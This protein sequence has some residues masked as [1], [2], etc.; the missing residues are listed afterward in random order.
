MTAISMNMGCFGSLGII[1]VLISP[2]QVLLAVLPGLIVAMLAAIA[3]LFRPRT[4]WN[5]LKLMWRLKIPLVIAAAV[6]V[7]MVWIVKTIWPAGR[8]AAASSEIAGRDWPMFR[9]GPGRCGAVGESDAPS[10]AAVK[11]I[12]KEGNIGFFCSPAVVGNRIYVTSADKDVFADA[13]AI[14]CLDANNR[15]V[16]WKTVPDGYLATFS[17]PVVSGDYVVC[18]EGLHKTQAARII[19]LRRTTG[20][21]VWMFR[22]NHHVECTPAVSEGRVY[23]GAGDD[24][25]YCLALEGGGNGQ[26]KVL[27]HLPSKDYPDAETSLVACG[28]KVYVGLGNKGQAICAIDGKT[29]KELGRIP[30]PYTVFSPPAVVGGKLY[31]GMGTGDFIFTAEE[32]HLP[33]AGEVWCVDLAG[34]KVDWKFKVSQ[35]VLGAI[36]ASPEGYELYFGSRDGNLYCIGTDGKQRWKWNAFSQILTSPAVTKNCVY[37]VT[38]SGALHAI[39]RGDGQPAWEQSLGS[40]GTFASSPSVS[41]SDVYV[42]T[43]FDGLFCLSQSA[44]KLTPV[45]AG[46][47]GS[48]GRAGNADDSALSDFGDF[49]WQYPADQSGQGKDAYVKAPPA[50]IG[51][52]LLVPL[53]EGPAKGVACLPPGGETRNK[54]PKPEW[55]FATTNGVCLSP[56]VSGDNVFAVDG[57]AGQAGRS[58]H[59][60]ALGNGVQR[61]RT[62]VAKGASG[63]MSADVAHVFVQD[64]NEAVSCFGMDGRRIWRQSVGVMDHPPAAADSML[65]AATTGK[66]ELVAMDL[67]TGL[68]LWRA[69]LDAAPTT[70]PVARNGVIY[71]GTSAGLEAR[72]A[73]DGKMIAGWHVEPGAAAGG[74]LSLAG[75]RIAYVNAKAELLV[76]SAED[77]HV[78]FRQAGVSPAVVPMISRDAILYAAKDGLKR[79]A[80]DAPDN[81][82]AAWA[83]TSWLGEPSTSMILCGSKIYI[84]MTGW[85][86]ACLGAGK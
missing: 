37:F 71:L 24:G 74:G 57:R 84:G 1:P 9:G 36:A 69:S 67:P 59:C 54:A 45:W 34:F 77:G 8:V 21:I 62:E 35:T 3:S 31:V 41:G 30:A 50:V 85:G 28:D 73:V 7:G 75:D 11:W 48:P 32:L 18:G 19:C 83:D 46:P 33:P 14:Y 4:M 42:G 51:S 22:T 29:G 44:G 39:R 78:I 66:P 82:P 55:F 60:I 25:I 27:W 26:P 53:A 20:Q 10:C 38:A 47:L 13:G 86:L 58:L 5:L 56:A 79:L 43:Q 23:V 81:K 2:L 65:I 64:E 17:S 12:F 6:V 63:V 76:V 52:K 72:G 49:H 68:V 15:D 80:L 61:W 70:G 16:I 40:K